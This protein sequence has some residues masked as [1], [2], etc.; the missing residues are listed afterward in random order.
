M[1]AKPFGNF[2]VEFSDYGRRNWLDKYGTAEEAV[3]AYDMAAWRFSWPKTWLN[4]LEIETRVDVELLMVVNFAIQST[5][6]K[7]NEKKKKLAERGFFWKREHE[8]KNKAVK[9]EEEVGPS[10]V[11]PIEFDSE[12]WGDLEEED[13]ECDDPSRRSSG[14]GKLRPPVTPIDPNTFRQVLQSR[15]LQAVN[16]NLACCPR[17]EPE[18]LFSAASPPPP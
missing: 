6:K 16:T 10:M 12:D 4:F 14:S 9:K 5:E 15:R 8:R 18:V 7:K 17:G 1:R 2:G 11:I 13:Q 3:H